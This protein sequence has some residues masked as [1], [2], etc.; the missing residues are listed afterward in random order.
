MTHFFTWLVALAAKI[1]LGVVKN[2][3][4]LFSLL[5]SASSVYYK[6]YRQVL[7][8]IDNL[9]CL[10]RLPTYDKTR[11]VAFHKKVGQRNY[12]N[13]HLPDKENESAHDLDS[14]R[15]IMKTIITKRS[16]QTDDA[17]L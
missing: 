10:L 14:F 15:V 7:T 13:W 2:V 4:G 8:P 11:L 16:L 3:F 17:K 6:S 9:Q 5:F 12:T 1:T